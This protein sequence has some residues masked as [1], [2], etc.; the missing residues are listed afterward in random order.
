M[1]F[2][3]SRSGLFGLRRWLGIPTYGFGGKRAVTSVAAFLLYNIE[4][5]E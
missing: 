5:C 1:T 3:A 2:Q 4:I